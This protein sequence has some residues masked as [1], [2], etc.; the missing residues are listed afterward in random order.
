MGTTH[1]VQAGECIGSIAQKYK[2]WWEDLWNHPAN[3]KLKEKRKNPN[4]IQA[5]DLLAIP[6]PELRVHSRQTGQ[7]H[8]FKV[9]RAKTRL[10]LRI[11]VDWGPKPAATPTAPSANRRDVVV[12]DPQPD[13]T[14]RQDEARGG[15]TYQLIV[16]GVTTD[17]TTDSD[18]YLD[19]EIP[20]DAM[21]GQLILSP[22]TP[23][24]TVMPLNLG[25]LDPIDEVSGVK[26]RLRNLCFDCGDQTDE[27]TPDF[28]A[29]VGAFQL[30]HGLSVTGKVDDATRA[31]LLKAHGT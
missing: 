28:E 22:G 7:I 29:A 24:E 15:I 9:K 27:T 21:S 11:V 26:Q 31:E 13:T 10:K 30:K 2:L 20:A 23:H 6:T 25:H 19:C 5:G 12:E 18:G 17:G 3:A 16:D 4:V 8:P 14:P 1:R